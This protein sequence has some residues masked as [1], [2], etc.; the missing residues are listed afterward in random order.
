[1]EF[2]LGIEISY[3]MQSGS[4]IIK[5]YNWKANALEPGRLHVKSGTLKREIISAPWLD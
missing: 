4:D 5:R 3:K 1:M 2:T